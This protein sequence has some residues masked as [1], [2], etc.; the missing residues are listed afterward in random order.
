MLITSAEVEELKEIAGDQ[1]PWDLLAENAGSVSLPAV[2]DLACWAK[3]Q[4]DS[5][6]KLGLQTCLRGPNLACV[7]EWIAGTPRILRNESFRPQ[8]LE[9]ALVAAGTSQS[10]EFYFFQERFKAAIRSNGFSVQLASALV[11]ALK[12]LVENVEQ[13]SGIAGDRVDGLVGYQVHGARVTF[14]IGDTGC[15]VLASLH[16]NPDWALLKNSA[17]ALT[18]IV[19]QRASRRIALGDGEGI[20]QLFKSLADLNGWLR[21]R[22]GD[23]FVELRGNGTARREA[24]GTAVASA[25]LQIA[26]TCSL[27]ALPPGAEEFPIDIL[28]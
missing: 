24:R 16:K 4:A 28:I 2:I 25:G 8:S 20:K 7:R 10:R 14:S 17:A 9:F 23:A 11:G 3:H 12:E 18:A 22:S 26:V 6:D 21:F 27:T 13:H 1:P 15:G 5:S 19:H